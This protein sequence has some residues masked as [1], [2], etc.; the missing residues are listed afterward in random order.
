MRSS[1]SGVARRDARSIQVGEG[2]EA[3]GAVKDPRE[4]MTLIGR[5][6]AQAW[7]RA[8]PVDEGSP[9]TGGVAPLVQTRALL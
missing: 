5:R 4:V 6:G 7:S 1:A 9:R 2:Q 3:A 8:R